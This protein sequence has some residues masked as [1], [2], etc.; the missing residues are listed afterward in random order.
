M[1]LGSIEKGFFVYIVRDFFRLI[2]RILL[3]LKEVVEVFVIFC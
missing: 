1:K 3:M 2:V